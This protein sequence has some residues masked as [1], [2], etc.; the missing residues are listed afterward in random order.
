VTNTIVNAHF[1]FH[2]PGSSSVVIYFR[3]TS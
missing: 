3:S 2:F 1:Q